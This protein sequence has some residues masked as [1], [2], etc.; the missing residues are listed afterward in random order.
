MGDFF[1]WALT[2]QVSKLHVWSTGNPA[3]KDDSGAVAPS[4][5]QGAIQQQFLLRSGE[6]RETPVHLSDSGLAIQNGQIATVVWTARAGATH[7]HCVYVLNRSTGA[8]ARL[9]ASLRHIRSQ[10]SAGR[11]ILYGALATIPAA[12]ALM[13]WLLIP[14]AFREIDT[15]LFLARGAIA[16]V[17]LFTVGAIVAKLAFDWLRSEDDDK[18]WAA[19]ARAVDADT[20][21][22]QDRHKS[23]VASRA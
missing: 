15:K 10:V 11:I 20:Q 7:G 16:L 19:V 8:Y 13:A 22:M 9:P 21:R 6:D 12:L 18:I 14:G 1:A 23:P 17:V 4:A 5:A 2:G 3:E